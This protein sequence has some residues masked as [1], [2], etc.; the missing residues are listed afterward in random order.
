MLI[1]ENFVWFII[2]VF[3][4]FGFVFV[5]EVFFCLYIVIVIFCLIFFEGMIFFFF[6]ELLFCCLM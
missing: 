6:G 4:G 2:G 1:I 5:K 3:F